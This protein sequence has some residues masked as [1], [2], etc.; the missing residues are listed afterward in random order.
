MRADR[1]RLNEALAYLTEGDVLVVWKLDRLAR[2]LP[3]LIE[4][5]A[6]LDR[7]GIGFRSLTE[8]IDT[9]TTGG[10]LTFHIF[11]AL[12]QFERDIIRERT[13]A[14]LRPPLREGGKVEGPGRWERSRLRQRGAFLRA[15]C[16]SRTSPSHSMSES[17]PCTATA[18]PVLPPLRQQREKCPIY[19]DAQWHLASVRGEG[20]DRL[21]RYTPRG[22]P[23]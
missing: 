16:R 19:Y 15:A 18:S 10:P 14:G 11:G 5:V 22:A 23:D 6:D 2:S 8:N 13:V 12:A 17:A 21:R 20:V 7:R 3:H 1:P 4:I 9:T